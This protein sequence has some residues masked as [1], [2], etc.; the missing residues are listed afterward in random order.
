MQEN[1]GGARNATES[2]GYFVADDLRVSSIETAALLQ[3]DASL[4]RRAAGGNTLC[5]IES[6]MIIR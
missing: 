5:N 4:L 3:Q 2:S 1:H 6:N